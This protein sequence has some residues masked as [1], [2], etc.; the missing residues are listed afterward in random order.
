MD[1]RNFAIFYP[2]L[3]A[4]LRQIGVDAMLGCDQTPCGPGPARHVHPDVAF[5]TAFVPA[6]TVWLVIGLTR[7]QW[8][9]RVWIPAVA[10]GLLI[11]VGVGGTA[12]R[13]R[14]LV[15]YWGVGRR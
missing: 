13:V 4:E 10:T 3:A 15:T 7:R 1:K 11:V 12:W 9:E 5:A 14:A 2:R 6:A 8:A